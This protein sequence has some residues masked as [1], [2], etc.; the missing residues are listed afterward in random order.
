M[1]FVRVGDGPVMDR[2]DRKC[3]FAGCFEPSTA[4]RKGPGNGVFRVTGA[5]LQG[6]P[7]RL[8][9]AARGGGGLMLG[10]G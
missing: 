2:A 9:D 8:H 3:R 1:Q 4:H 7:A 6:W 10:L 5:D